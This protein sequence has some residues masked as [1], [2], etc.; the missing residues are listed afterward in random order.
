MSLNLIIT[1]LKLHNS[2][3]HI[4]RK[5]KDHFQFFVDGSW[6]FPERRIYEPFKEDKKRSDTEECKK[7]AIK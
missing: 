6:L 2:I 4:T 7:I 1:L 5:P 3:I